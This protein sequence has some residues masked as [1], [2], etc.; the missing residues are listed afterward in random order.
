MAKKLTP[1]FKPYIADELD[2]GN[3]SEEFTDLVPIDS[4]AL[5]PT[6][7]QDIF[8]VSRSHDILERLTRKIAISINGT[9]YS[10]PLIIA[11]S[12]LWRNVKSHP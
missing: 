12:R 5:P 1:P 10:C 3:F 2:V 9:Q 8:R 6:K 7:H 11:T 4:P